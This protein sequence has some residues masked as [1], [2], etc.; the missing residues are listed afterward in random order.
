MQRWLLIKCHFD[1]WI[2]FKGPSCVIVL[3]GQHYRSR[4]RSRATWQK[5]KLCSDWCFITSSIMT[6]WAVR[7][8]FDTT[9]VQ[10][11]IIIIIMLRCWT[12]P[13]GA[14]TTVIFLSE[15]K[16]FPTSTV[17]CLWSWSHVW[18]VSHGGAFYVHFTISA[19]KYREAGKSLKAV[20]VCAITLLFWGRRVRLIVLYGI[21]DGSVKTH[22]CFGAQF[23]SLICR[24]SANKKVLQS[25]LDDLVM[26]R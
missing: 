26:S 19:K 11:L 18:C 4:T 5:D 14:S 9:D 22:F 20:S 8:I 12:Y 16:I 3:L 25:R 7:T 6:T 2:Y 23:I 13:E 21:I 10:I 24:I 17:L 15:Q 1:K